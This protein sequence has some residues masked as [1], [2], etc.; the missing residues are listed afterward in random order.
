MFIFI[1][2]VG[3]TQAY[4]YEMDTS[5]DFNKV[6]FTINGDGT[7]SMILYGD[8]DGD[9][10]DKTYWL[11]PLPSEPLVEILPDPITHQLFQA[12][13]PILTLPPN[14]CTAVSWM[15]G[16][17]HIWDTGSG[18]MDMVNTTFIE[19]VSLQHVIEALQTE[20]YFVDGRKL[21]LIHHYLQ[22]GMSFLLLT[23]DMRVGNLPVSPS[24]EISPAI[25]I[26]YRAETPTLPLLLTTTSTTE[27][28][29]WVWIFGDTRYIPQN[30]FH[31][32]LDDSQ[33]RITPTTHLFEQP[34]FLA[35]ERADH[36]SRNNPMALHSYHYTIQ[37]LHEKYGGMFVT[38]FAS[39]TST[40][41]DEID[42]AVDG[43]IAHLITQF[44]YVTRLRGQL[45][46]DEIVADEQFIP[47]PNM[48]DIGRERN[49]SEAV[50]PLHFWGCSSRQFIRNQ[51]EFWLDRVMIDENLV[52]YPQNWIQH[53][54]IGLNELPFTVF[55]PQLI[56]SDDVYDFFDRKSVPPMLIYISPDVLKQHPIDNVFSMRQILIGVDQTA[57]R[58]SDWLYTKYDEAKG[59]YRAVDEDMIYPE[60]KQ[61][62]WRGVFILLTTKADYHANQQ[63]YDEVFYAIDDYAFY[64]SPHLRHTLFLGTGGV[65]GYFGG[66]VRYANRQY[67]PS[68]YWGFPEGWVERMMPNDVVVVAPE[69]TPITFQTPAIRLIPFENVGL[70]PP[71][72]MYYV[73]YEMIMYYLRSRYQL[74]DI[75][76][77]RIAHNLIHDMRHA[78]SGYYNTFFYEVGGYKGYISFSYSDRVILEASAPTSL[79]DQYA[80][81]LRWS[82][83]S[84]RAVD[85]GCG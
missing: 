70:V 41:V 14:Y 82:A 77:Y 53:D 42:P 71:Q 52:S 31:P 61:I 35:Y 22:Q 15:E 79:F 55:S 34:I 20:G 76:L 67:V 65:I 26:T 29:I 51:A 80:D 85:M 63:L 66:N 28:A 10:K 62:S 16:D 36:Y 39:P 46:P 40:L 7:I 19:G 27:R 50:D 18:A 84:F 11:I 64:A 57:D 49:I 8:Y 81:I 59:L 38:E 2:W 56:T 83:D 1:G 9:G 54:L 13:E 4:D 58:D 45:N 44:P 6:I 73:P 32:I 78:C 33:F 47:A 12:T 21:T 74:D 23:V 75:G 72:K 48:P 25:K 5:T 37:Q 60:L 68:V 24:P 30:Y 3:I 17:L 69:N 43:Y